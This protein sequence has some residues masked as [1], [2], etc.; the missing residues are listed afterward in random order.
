[1]HLWKD[2]AQAMMTGPWTRTR[3]VTSGLRK[4]STSEIS[5]R[6]GGIVQIDDHE[7]VTAR[8]VSS[9]STVME[10]AASNP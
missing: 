1:M 4:D 3:K 9:T 8:V 7:N 6:A 10:E 2:N 5:N